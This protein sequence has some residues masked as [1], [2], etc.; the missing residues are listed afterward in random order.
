MRRFQQIN[1]G[2][3]CDMCAI[4][5]AVNTTLK[6]NQFKHLNNHMLSYLQLLS[7]FQLEMMEPAQPNQL[8]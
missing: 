5:T 1:C 7:A 4:C 2:S 8:H 6:E 3:Q